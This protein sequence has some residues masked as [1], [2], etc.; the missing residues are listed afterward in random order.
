[1]SARSHCVTCGIVAQA[2]LRCSA[3]LRRT[4][5]IGWRST[6]PQRVKSG[7]ATPAAAPPRPAPLVTSRFDVRL[8]IVDRDAAVG[9]GAGTSS[10][11]TPSSRAIRRTDGAAGAGGA[12]GAGGLGR[13]P[14]AAADVDDVGAARVAAGGLR[15]DRRILHAGLVRLRRPILD[16]DVGLP[17]PRSTSTFSALPSR[18]ALAVGLRAVGFR[19]F[20]GR[21]RRF[22]LRR[23]RLR[24]GA[25]GAACAG[26]VVDAEDR[27]ADL[28]LVA[29]LDLDLL[30]G[31]GDRRRHF[32][33]RL[34]GFELEDRLFLGDRV[35]RLHQHAQDVAGLDVLAELWEC[36]IVRPSYVRDDR[37]D[38][39]LSR[40]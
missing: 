10:M 18:R 12:S 2:A 37:R 21:R 13:R 33:R 22:G 29:G 34:V 8:H 17:L 14:R 1:M 36:E 35:A 30:D 31:A 4:A 25:C 11:S 26:A 24:R 3:V 7:S 19:R 27:L 6:P 9:A 5:R 32:D 38:S 16:L 39:A 20:A 40:D 23:R 15:P 28:D